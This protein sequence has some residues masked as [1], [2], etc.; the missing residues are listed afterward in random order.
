MTCYQCN[1]PAVFTEVYDGVDIGV[2]PDGHRTG[3]DLRPALEGSTKDIV[4]V[5]WFEVEKQLIDRLKKAS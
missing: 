4:D 3:L 1:K 2:C 5:D